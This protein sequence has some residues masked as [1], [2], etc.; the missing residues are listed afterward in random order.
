MLAWFALPKVP[1]VNVD[2]PFLLILIDFW[3]P[4]RRQ[5]GRKNQWK[6]VSFFD[7][8]FFEYR[9][10][11]LADF[12]RFFGAFGRSKIT[13]KS[14]STR[15]S[16]KW[17]NLQKHSKVL[18]KSRFAGPAVDAKMSLRSDLRHEKNTSSDNRRKSQIFC[19][20]GLHFWTMMGA[21]IDVKSRRK[22]S[23]TSMP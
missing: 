2:T 15:S 21:K 4:F 19:R 11:V 14:F 22:M 7:A 16:E 9:G 12:G 13:S 17:K 1:L 5:F 6:I 23:R 10:P 8:D 18:L 20:F 3:I